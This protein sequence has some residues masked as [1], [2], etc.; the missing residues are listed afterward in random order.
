MFGVFTEAISGTPFLFFFV[1]DFKLLECKLDFQVLLE[2]FND[3][4]LIENQNKL[5]NALND[6]CLSIIYRKVLIYIY[7]YIYNYDVK[8]ININ[9]V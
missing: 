1:D 4:L 3:F 5:Q 6:I 2:T 9:R 8:N 7:S